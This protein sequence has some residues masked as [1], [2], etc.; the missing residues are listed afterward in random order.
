MQLDPN[1]L[2]RP[3]REFAVRILNEQKR[4]ESQRL[5]Y[6]LHGD[7]DTIWTGLPILKGAIVPGQTIYGRKGYQRHLEHF[8]AGAQYKER[9][10]MA[11]N[12]VSKTLGAGAY[13]TACHLT[14]EYPRWWEGRR[15]DTPISAWVAGKTAETTR[16]ILQITLLGEVTS[17]GGRKCPDGRGVVPGDRL[18]R[19]TWKAGSVQD[20][21]DNIQVKHNS[22]GTSILGFKAYEQGRGAFEG[23]ALH[24]VWFDEEPD[25]SVYT[26]ALTRTMTTNGIVIL[27]FTPLEGLSETV[28]SFMPAEMR[29]GQGDDER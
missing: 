4:R 10:L 15:F 1:S 22:G 20:C 3:E 7:E 27:T 28:L 14:G 8:A 16:D 18:G 13:E 6:R 11:A 23:T 12:R 5:F 9:C 21:I 2:T 26:E 24:L 29:P 19:V 17:E 25:I